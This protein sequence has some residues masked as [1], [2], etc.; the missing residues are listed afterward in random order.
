MAETK[1]EKV[2]SFNH[3]F[4]RRSDEGTSGKINFPTESEIDNETRYVIEMKDATGPG[5]DAEDISPITV[6]T[7]SEGNNSFAIPKSVI[8]T[9]EILPG[10]TVNITVHE[11]EK[12]DE[13]IQTF[14]DAAV[15]GRA[16]VAT[17]RKNSDE[18]YPALSSSELHEMIPDSVAMFKF[19]NVS[20]NKETVGESSRLSSNNGIKF[21]ISVREDI[22]AEPGDLIEVINHDSVND[23]NDTQLE[24]TNGEKIDE[25]YEMVSELYD[26]YTA[27]KN[28]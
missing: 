24:L 25:M 27:A 3:T 9:H 20:K 21:P 10:H 22:D 12:P 19:R 11:Y 16:T 2:V 17:D 7:H 8:E 1:G 14:S 18:C 15:L 28:D 4:S 5:F 6:K 13:D 26:A 23:D